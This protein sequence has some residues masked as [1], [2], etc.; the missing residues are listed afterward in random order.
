M[1]PELHNSNPFNNILWI[2]LLAYLNLW[3]GQSKNRNNMTLKQFSNEKRPCI[4]ILHLSME[5]S[6]QHACVHT[7]LQ[8]M[9]PN[10]WTNDGPLIVKRLNGHNSTTVSKNINHDTQTRSKNFIFVLVVN[11]I[12]NYQLNVN[13]QYQYYVQSYVLN[14]I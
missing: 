11:H 12:I 7:S 5:F 4:N 10:I 8:L 2:I 1:K 6:I 13:L 9:Q 14:K 3:V